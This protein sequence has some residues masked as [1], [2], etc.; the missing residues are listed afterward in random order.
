FGGNGL[1]ASSPAG[2]EAEYPADYARRHAGAIA[3]VLADLAAQMG[4]QSDRGQDSSGRAEDAVS[5]GLL[6]GFRWIR[7][8]RVP[9][10]EHGQA[11]EGA[12]CTPRRWAEPT[13]GW[14]VVH[15]AARALQRL[16][17][18]AGGDLRVRHSA[19]L[20]RSAGFRL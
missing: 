1:R 19:D 9:K 17:Q 12:P 11:L 16:Q 13:G 20:R 7:V 3:H 6:C 4:V 18:P 14:R 2:I 15:F 5:R 8:L 10:R